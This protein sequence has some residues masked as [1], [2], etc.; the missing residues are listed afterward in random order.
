[1]ISASFTSLLIPA[2]E[3]GGIVPTAVGFV[4]GA[5]VIYSMDRI[6]PYKHIVKG[7]EGS[8]KLRRKLKV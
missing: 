4:L 1:M 8:E 3:V 2:V 7:Y 6:L 5:L